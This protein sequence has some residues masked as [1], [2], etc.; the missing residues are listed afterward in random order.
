[1]SNNEK[2]TVYDVIQNATNEGNWINGE[3]E[4][5]VRNGKQGQ[6]RKPSTADLC[7]PHSPNVKIHASWFG[8]GDFT[9]F[10]GSLCLFGGQGMK[11]SLYKG[12]SQVSMSSKSTVNVL[13][14]GQ[15]PARQSMPPP[16]NNPPPQSQQT[17]A[18]NNP[19]LSSSDQS[20]SEKVFHNGM[21]KNALFWMHCW[22]YAIQIQ[23]K[24]GVVFGEDQQ[25]SLVASLFIEGNK[26]G[27]AERTPAY[28]P[29]YYAAK[30][31]TQTPSRQATPPPA[32]NPP[33]QSQQTPDDEN[34]P[35]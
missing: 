3:F 24:L 6:G 26:S 19:P 31:E 33:P 28:N 1:M 35:F 18:A 16:P 4:A 30:S 14:A 34:V 10:E 12:N 13:Q 32:N 11:A 5:I 22:R 29:A 17:P 15:T 20:P 23:E 2:V 9:R 25:Q 21:K 7:D 8:G 27:L